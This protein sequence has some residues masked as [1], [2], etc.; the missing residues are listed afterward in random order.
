MPTTI[1]LEP[2]LEAR[3]R[4]LAEDTGRS[5]AYY[6]R[7][8]LENEIDDL[9]WTYHILRTAEEVRSGKQKTYSLAEVREEL[10][11]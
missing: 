1:R 6:F 5:Q 2:E 7:Q 3:Y 4:K 10:G 11:L 8:A 9:E